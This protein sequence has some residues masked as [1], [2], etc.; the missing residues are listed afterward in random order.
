MRKILATVAVVCLC[1][2]TAM[3]D[4][5]SD[6]S[7][8]FITITDD[9]YDGTLG[10]MVSDSIFVTGH[11]AGN[12]VSLITVDITLAHTWTGDLIIALGTPNGQI[13]GLVSRP[14]FAEVGDGSGC[15][16]NNGDWFRG[17]SANFS[18]AGSVSGELLFDVFG[19][20]T[21]FAAPEATVAFLGSV[22]DFAALNGQLANGSWTLYIG[23]A[24]AGDQGTFES[25]TINITSIPA[26]GALAL[27]GMA[28]LVSRRRRRA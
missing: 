25:W 4:F 16:G 8:P 9:G 3:A 18:D 23:D 5:T 14:G 27:L 22:A 15:C 17:A 10:S 1:T 11:T 24:A 12:I 26:P 28:G 7:N 20:E 2:S 21:F 19:G 13:L 6:T